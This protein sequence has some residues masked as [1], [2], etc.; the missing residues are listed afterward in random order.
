[1]TSRTVTLDA[2]EL[3]GSPASIARYVQATLR[4]DPTY[5]S[6]YADTNRSAQ[7]FGTTFSLVSGQPRDDRTVEHL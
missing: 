4:L 5:R 7:T 2:S 6:P 3:Q 1:M